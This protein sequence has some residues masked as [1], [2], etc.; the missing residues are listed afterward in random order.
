LKKKCNTMMNR[1]N[2][3]LDLLIPK[4]STRH[5]RLQLCV[6]AG[7][8][9]YCAA[10]FGQTRHEY[11]GLST[12]WARPFAMGGAF[13]AVSDNLPALLYNPANFTLY[14]D[15]QTRKL[16]LF[17]NPIGL[18]GGIRRH[19]D[20]HGRESLG[21]KELAS[22]LELFVHGLAFG[23]SSFQIV[24]LLGEELPNPPGLVRDDPLEA[25]HYAAN[26]YSLMAG[27]IQFT[28]RVAIGG[29]VGIYYQ[30]T[31]TGRAWG[32]GWSYGV[33]LL[34]GDKM[35]IGLSYWS[36]PKN[37]KQ[38]RLNPER[39][40][41]EAVNLG[42]SYKAPT[43]TL[44]AID[45]RNLGEESQQPVRELHLGVEQNIFQWVALRGG[46]Y[47]DRLTRRNLWSAGI[48]LLDQNWWRPATSQKHEPDW[49]IQYGVCFEKQ[50]SQD[51]YQHALTFLIR[52]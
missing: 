33:T 21:D 8:L 34:S 41:H 5:R 9:L 28:K 46:F 38:Y 48:G 14:R 24:A 19:R 43:G 44:L 1:K 39:L 47:R 29:S 3:V 35:R 16:T 23:D 22:M 27:R 6:V 37:M 50:V 26:Q 52:L 42:L 49:A 15:Q 2:A 32:T 4:F 31:A 51:V 36:F 7:T 25:K 40:V 20:L 17:F 45:I 11:Y 30:D 18:S 12:S 10:A 13:T